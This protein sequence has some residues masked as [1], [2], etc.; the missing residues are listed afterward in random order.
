MSSPLLGYPDF[1]NPKFPRLIRVN[2]IDGRDKTNDRTFVDSESDVMIG[3]F[4]KSEHRV[5][6]DRIVENTIG[7]T[8]E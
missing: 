7:D 6:G 3:R 4:Q 2:V 5:A 8:L 1:V